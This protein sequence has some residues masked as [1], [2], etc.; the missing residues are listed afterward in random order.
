MKR[1]TMIWAIVSLLIL[2]APAGATQV[3]QRGKQPIYT[4]TINVA[5]ENYDGRQ[6][7]ASESIDDG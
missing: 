6:L 5:A 1:L 7:P 4:I 3:Q 2:G